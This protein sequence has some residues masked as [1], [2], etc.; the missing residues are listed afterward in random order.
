MPARR[1]LGSARQGLEAAVGLIRH[2]DREKAHPYPGVTRQRIVD[3]ETGS[4]ALST[5]LLTIQPGATATVHR[6]KIEEA[7]LVIA[8]EG[9]AILGDEQFPIKA[10]E[11]LLAPAGVRHGFI[12]T[13]S[14][15]M[16]VSGIFP[17]VDIEVFFDE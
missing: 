6:H 3:R 11:T 16:I 9:L 15:P 4:G 14:Q 1:V 8:G 2:D 13:G 12:N 10:N 17:A 7:M 5:A